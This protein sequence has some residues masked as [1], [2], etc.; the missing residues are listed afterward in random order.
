[1]MPDALCGHIRGECDTAALSIVPGLP[2]VGHG[3]LVQ[4]QSS[5]NVRTTL[6]RSSKI[7]DLD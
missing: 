2:L 1:M 7:N 6:L 5:E 3:C 4:A